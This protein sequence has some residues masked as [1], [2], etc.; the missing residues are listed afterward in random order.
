MRRD[1]EGN[2]RGSFQGINVEAVNKNGKCQF[3]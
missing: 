3:D 1:S 2:G